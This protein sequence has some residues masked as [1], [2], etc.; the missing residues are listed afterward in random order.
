MPSPV[1][2][3]EILKMAIA[4]S[5]EEEEDPRVQENTMI[6]VNFDKVDIGL[7]SNDFSEEPIQEA[8]MPDPVRS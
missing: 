4:M 5:L 2:E 7:K 1:D 3:D 6:Q 8:E